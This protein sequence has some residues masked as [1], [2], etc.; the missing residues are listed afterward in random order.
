MPEGSSFD[1]GVY[2]RSS[3]QIDTS[4][5]ITISA[6]NDNEV[7]LDSAISNDSK[8]VL[9][10]T[11]S[12]ATTN[13]TVDDILVTN[14]T[15]SNFTAI[16]STIY[17]T[18]LTPL[19]DGSITVNVPMNVF[20][21]IASNSNTSSDQFNWTYDGTPPNMT[22]SVTNGINPLPD[23]AV[24]ADTSLIVTFTTNEPIINL[25]SEDIIVEGGGFLSFTKTSASIYTG[26]FAPY[27]V[28]DTIL[29]KV[30]SS[31]FTDLVGN[32]NTSMSQFNWIY[33]P[34]EE[35]IILTFNTTFPENIAN[36]SVIG[37]IE[38][39]DPDGDV[40][41]YSIVSGNEK[42]AFML[43][44]STGELTVLDNSPLDFEV[45]PTFELLI[46]VSDGFHTT[47]ATINISISDVLENE[48]EEET[49]SLADASEMIYPNPSKGII[50]I[51]MLDF[52]EATIYNFLGQE[53]LKS[54]ESRIDLSD[55]NEG[56]YIIKLE[57]RSGVSVSTKLVKE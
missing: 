42:G 13:F 28:S 57:D 18:N 21:D 9:T 44:S 19:N 24:T 31:I 50:N 36:G 20:T 1:I 6:R 38:A 14:G 56:V 49:L 2:E 27:V 4:P 7:V 29:I 48:E 8:L 32:T 43:D 16:S 25:N 54:R 15:L 30:L 11:T 40:L 37:I 55:L 52:K 10:F 33:D 39:I 51:N 12:Q 22:I 17:T 53:V 41:S 23:G 3:Q 26:T 47:S 45:N 35:P 34:N 5:T 46:S